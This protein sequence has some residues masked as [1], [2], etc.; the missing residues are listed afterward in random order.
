M[1]PGTPGFIG[2]KLREAREA[3]VLNASVLADILGVSRQA[4]S[5]YENGKQTP[6]PQVMRRI[7]EVLN[8]PPHY[9]LTPSLA[10]SDGTLY[11]RSLASATKAVRLGVE[12]RFG[13]M[14]SIEAF[15]RG[16][17]T[18]PRANLP[19]FDVPND[20]G[21]LDDHHVEAMATEARRFWGLKDGPISNVTWLI[22]NNGVIM[23]R[24]D[25]GAEKLDAFSQ[26]DARNGAPYVVLGADKASAARS[27]FDAAHELAHLLL[28]KRLGQTTVN[29]TT[30]H[31]LIEGQ[32]H[33]F[34][35]AFLLPA[36][37][38]AADLYGN[39]S[40]SL[41]RSLKEKWRVSIALM[42]M[43]SKKLGIIGPEQARRLW[44]NYSSNGWKRGEPYDDIFEPEQPRLLRRSIELLVDR[45]VIP[46]EEIPFRLALSASDI[47]KIVGLPLGYFGKDDGCRV[48]LRSGDTG[49][50]NSR[51]DEP[52]T[53]KFPT[54]S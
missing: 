23:A 37:S 18:F 21:R 1:R 26:W 48:S 6:A 10:S 8:V 13:W 16:Y 12:R 41:F 51:P 49:D 27:R 22:E 46:R 50:G 52:K 28:H 29:T 5:Q 42:I 43:R 4:V 33:R 19:D 47:E 39:P 45:N 2:A 11:W 34:A 9:F 17:L 40:L 44:I 32:A 54:A 15:L 7:A 20:I 31:P 35:G 3:R 30:L 14:R 24:F 53:L 38:F 25:L 36:A